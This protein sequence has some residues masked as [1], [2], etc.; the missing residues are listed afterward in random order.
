MPQNAPRKNRQERWERAALL[1]AEDQLTEEQI[2][3]DCGVDRKTLYRWRQLA[4]FHAAVEEHRREWREQLKA[5]GLA[6]RQNRI[7]ALNDRWGR[8]RRVI[9]AR[10]D[11]H[12]DAPGGDTGLLVRQV[13][14]VKVYNVEAE[15]PEEGEERDGETLFSAKRSVE[16]SEYAVDTSL[17][18]ELREH[19]KQA[20]QELGEWTEKKELSGK[21]GGPISVA[22]IDQVLKNAAAES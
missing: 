18:K 2:A 19:E 8:L 7:D 6:D 15:P 11:L 17:L 12:K 16:V 10:A 14:L 4:A 22:L 9:D 5:K 1:V 13:K 20:A 3:G 21:D